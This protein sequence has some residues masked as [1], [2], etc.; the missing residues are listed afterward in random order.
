MKGLLSRMEMFA[1]PSDN[2]I[3]ADVAFHAALARAT[4]NPLFPVLLDLVV[5]VLREVR[6]LGARVPR[7]LE[8]SKG[9]HRAIFARVEA[10]DEAGAREAMRAHLEDSETILSRALAAT[11]CYRTN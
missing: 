8:S 1:V 9:H 3:E 10:A 7:S 2:Y 4:A 6:R 11:P 5:D